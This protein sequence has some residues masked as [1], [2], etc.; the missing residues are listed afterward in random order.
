ML[1][2]QT[3]RDATSVALQGIK[4]ISGLLDV[5]SGQ[6]LAKIYADQEKTGELLIVGA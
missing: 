3:T 2:D 1:I 6:N 4:R 5:Y